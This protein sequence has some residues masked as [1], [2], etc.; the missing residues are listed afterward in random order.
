[1][2]ESI[3]VTRII[4]PIQNSTERINS[5]V[6]VLSSR[7]YSLN[8]SPKKQQRTDLITSAVQIG[9]RRRPAPTTSRG[10]AARPGDIVSFGSDESVI[11]EAVNERARECKGEG[12]K[13]KK[14][15]RRGLLFGKGIRKCNQFLISMRRLSDYETRSH[16]G[17]HSD[18]KHDA[19]R[20]N[21]VE[22]RCVIVRRLYNES[23]ESVARVHP[24]PQI[25]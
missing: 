16:R 7:I 2:P 11:D 12:K 10:V 13:K 1:M 21:C 15:T 25:Q 23:T 8:R 9:S 14:K 22:S 24:H 6:R 20:G 19:A 17:D 4:L 3:I 5:F 18:N